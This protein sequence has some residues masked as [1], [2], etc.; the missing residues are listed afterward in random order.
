[1]HALGQVLIGAAIQLTVILLM[2][3]VVLLFTRKSRP[4]GRTR[5][6]L[7]GLCGVLTISV[8]ALSPW[9][10]WSRFWESDPTSVAK[11]S[12]PLEESTTHTELST[13]DL[14]AEENANQAGSAKRSEEEPESVWS[15]AWLAA[16]STLL[17]PIQG[18][19]ISAK[20]DATGNV[21]R[22]QEQ[23]WS[24]S[25]IIAWIFLG[26]LS[27]GLLRLFA[28]M[29]LLKR[30][31]S[32]S[33]VLVEDRV[34]RAIAKICEPAKFTK[35]IEVR[36]SKTLQTAAT[37][38]LFHPVIL[39]PVCWESWNEEEL[40]AVLAHELNHITRRDCI[41]TFVAELLRVLH[42]YHP[43]MHWLAS[44]L[45]LE[46]E[47]AADAQ[48]ARFLGGQ[49][50]YLCILAQMALSESSRA[51]AWP[52]RAFLPS[53][54][55]FMR[56]I[57]MLRSSPL[58]EDRVSKLWHF[59]TLAA[60]G[61]ATL[62]ALGLRSP[63]NQVIAQDAAQPEAVIQV[64]AVTQLGKPIVALKPFPL[65][66]VPDDAIAVFAVRPKSL[67]AKPELKP[68]A[69]MLMKSE[70]SSQLMGIPLHEI[71]QVVW[72]M[73]TEDT[74]RHE[75]MLI[76]VMVKSSKKLELAALKE[77]ITPEGDTGFY[78]GQ[79]YLKNPGRNAGPAFWLANENTLI[80]SF[81]EDGLKQA[82]D[83]RNLA[84]GGKERIP[85]WKEVATKSA[86]AYGNVAQLRKL[87]EAG[88]ADPYLRAKTPQ[89]NFNK[90]MGINPMFGPLWNDV[91]TVIGGLAFDQKI[92]VRA[93]LT[94]KDFQAST[95]VFK[96][97]GAMQVLGQ[98]MIEQNKQMIGQLGK[99]EQQVVNLF[100][101][102]ADEVLKSLKIDH[103]VTSNVYVQATLP[104]NT[105]KTVI[106]ILQP[107]MESAQEAALRATTMNNFKQV[108][109]AFHNY[110][111]VYNEFPKPVMIGKDGKTPHSW[112]VALLP[113]ID[114]NDLYK[115]YRFDEPWDSEH[116]KT[117]IAKMPEIY[118][119]PKD[120][121]NSTNTSVFAL[122]GKSTM[123]GDG[124][125]K[126]HFRDVTDGTSN[127][128][129]FVEAKREIPWTKPED[130][131]YNEDRSKPVPKV[132]SWFKAGFIAGFGDGSVKMLQADIDKTSL[133]NLIERNDGNVVH[134]E[135][136]DTSPRRRPRD[137]PA[138]SN[139]ATA[140]DRDSARDEGSAEAVDPEPEGVSR[141]RPRS[142]DNS[143]PPCE[144]P[145]TAR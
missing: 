101:V 63:A 79:L 61:L 9:P 143:S 49:K 23:P 7:F 100:L 80:Y 88:P 132:G 20:P 59:A 121:K 133:Q 142:S 21:Q 60:I 104:E 40:A 73:G 18:T 48:A 139:K 17:Q 117:L 145:R 58:T 127:T 93:T 140:P 114:Q 78:G 33:R 51:P 66:Y 85:A 72:S 86:A 124:K 30:E 28:G 15:A 136:F 123:M 74:P 46:Q 5:L 22:I 31:V 16:K 37:T 32:R 4:T 38:G 8:F 95:K 75:P 68:V 107:A 69:E 34:N 135:D 82:I 13:P 106:G 65:T 83:A 96:T 97:L 134:H 112:R 122:T 138:S 116:N 50:R 11:V 62:F 130:L 12:S 144:K 120:K 53:H 19:T 71:E 45:R 81:S 54:R 105:T 102:M 84:V 3:W 119:H 90:V 91:E 141:P 110:T 14:L 64:E 43:L 129:L 25:S 113:Y 76:A 55:T 57:E 6:L 98:N 10:S 118:R 128:L 29:W 92:D 67:L 99:E 77:E 94:C 89:K 27:L 108:G 125:R 115:Q 56:R 1:M 103:R 126:M 35:P 24:V 36:V 44:R 47:L 87:I 137:N 41:T 111:D 109:L 39:L 52:A 70:V 42:F 131:T 26:G 2:L